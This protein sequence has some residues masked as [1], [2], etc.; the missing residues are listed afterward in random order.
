MTGQF[1]N[2][3]VCNWMQRQCC[4]QTDVIISHTHR[5]NCDP[6]LIRWS[7]AGSSSSIPGPDSGENYDIRLG[8]MLGMALDM[9]IGSNRRRDVGM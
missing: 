9:I 4:I 5:D 2:C 8:V 7:T 1:L 6:E 3:I